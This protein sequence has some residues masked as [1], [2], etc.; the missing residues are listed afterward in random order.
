MRR[1]S[2]A[3]VLAGLVHATLATA[4]MFWLNGLDFKLFRTLTVWS[5]V[6]V[7]GRRGADDDGNRHA[8]AAD[9]AGRCLLRTCCWCWRSLP[10]LF[11]LR[12]QPGFGELFLLWAIVMGP[13]TVVIVLL[14]NRAWR[15][16]GLTA[17]FALHRSDGGVLLGF[18]LVGCAV[19]TT[20][21][22]A[23]FDVKKLSTVLR[24]CLLA[25]RWPGCCCGARRDAIRPSKR[26][27][28]CLPWITGGCS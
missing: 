2:M 12:Y 20:K 6:R 14:A 4:I 28:R 7:A 19:L 5:S 3:Y 10:R 23:L 11:G 26:A 24:S 22:V 15:S 13:P 21:S 18:Q 25:A 27:T 8:Q 16:V 9:A 17:L 1:L